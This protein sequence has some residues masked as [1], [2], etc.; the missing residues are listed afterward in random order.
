[1]LIIVNHCRDFDIKFDRYKNG[2]LGSTNKK[3]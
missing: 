2:R 1:M 3:F